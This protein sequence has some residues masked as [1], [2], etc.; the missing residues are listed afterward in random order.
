MGFSVI[1]VNV[2]VENVAARLVWGWRRAAV[3]SKYRVAARSR[4]VMV[5]DL[6][7]AKC[8]RSLV[9]ERTISPAHIPP[10]IHD[11]Y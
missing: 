6:E 11:E 2:L 8:C 4:S 10:A 7:W 9:V 5:G 1:N 3:V